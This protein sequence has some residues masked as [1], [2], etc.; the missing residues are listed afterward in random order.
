MSDA[1]FGLNHFSVQDFV[2]LAG[3]YPVT[4]TVIHGRAPQGMDCPYQQ[5]AYAVCKIPSVLSLARTMPSTEEK[6]KESGF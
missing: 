1:T 2:R 5:R 3:Q 6:Q 4:W